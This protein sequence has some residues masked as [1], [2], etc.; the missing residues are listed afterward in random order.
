MSPPAKPKQFNFSFGTQVTVPDRFLIYGPPGVGKT[1]LASRFPRPYFLDPENG[2]KNVVPDDQ[3]FSDFDPRNDAENWDR[4][5]AWLSWFADGEH[6]YKT[7]VIDTVDKLFGYAEAWICLNVG[8]YDKDTKKTLPVNTLDKV[9]GGY[10][11]GADALVEQT[12]TFLGLLEQI[13]RSHQMNIVLL[14]HEHV[15]QQ[16][17]PS[18]D[19]FAMWAPNMNKKVLEVFMREMDY[20]LHAQPHTIVEEKKGD[21]GAKRTVTRNSEKRYLYCKTR[22]DRRTKCRR[23]LPD[24]IEF[25]YDALLLAMKNAGDPAFVANA[26]GEKITSVEDEKTRKRM[27]KS[28]ADCGKDIG[29]ICELETRVDDYLASIAQPETQAAPEA[30]SETTSA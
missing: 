3:R 2:S 8:V 17:V 14:S 29:A 19:D 15:A 7:L 18:G 1:T 22:S 30:Q 23:P 10:A 6:G 25:N 5:L 12:R 26:L 9:G 28:L 13:G 16:K 20:V 24:R 4:T 21:F 11:R 27:L